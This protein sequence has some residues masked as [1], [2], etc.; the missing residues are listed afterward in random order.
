[1]LFTFENKKG[2]QFFLTTEKTDWLDGVHVVF[3]QV[4]EGLNVVK[5]MEV[6]YFIL[7]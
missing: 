6:I 3:G 4:V 1:L 5:K 7:N 2:S